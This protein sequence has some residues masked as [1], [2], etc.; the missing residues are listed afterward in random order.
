MKHYNP[1]FYEIQ[2]EREA[3]IIQK[4]I[5]GE[6]GKRADSIDGVPASCG[7]FQQNYDRSALELYYWKTCPPDRYFIYVTAPEKVGSMT[8]ASTVVTTWMG[9]VMG[10]AFLGQ[11]YRSN[12]GDKRRSITVYGNNGRE[13]YGTYFEGAG[14]YARIT[15]RRGGNS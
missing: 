1:R 9:Q 3:V 10:R 13:Y 7:T 11:S 14:D 8:L 12:M 5:D 4:A 2:S 15:M 6:Y